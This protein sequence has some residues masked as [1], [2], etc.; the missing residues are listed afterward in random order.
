MSAEAWFSY[1]I[2]TLLICVTPGP[3]MMLM[4]AMGL[5]HGLRGTVPAMLGALL[6]VLAMMVASA[7]GLGFVLQ[8]SPAAFIV[9]KSL[10]AAY[11]A[12]L[13]LQLLLRPAHSSTM[14]LQ[15]V[16]TSADG[17]GFRSKLGK[18]MAV[19]GSNPKAIVFAAAWFPQFI[20]AGRAAWPQLAVL[21]PTFVVLELGCYVMYALSGQALANWFARPGVLRVVNCVIGVI[22]IAFGVLLAAG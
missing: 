14:P 12:W 18:A 22:F 11:L 7:L 13:G 17:V 9:L 21:L 10:G 16:G 6:V 19:A 5:Q 2:A 8:Q 15:Q 3:N 4:L 20:D 1:A